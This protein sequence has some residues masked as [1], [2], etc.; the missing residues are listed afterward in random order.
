MHV[1][2]ALGCFVCCKEVAMQLRKF[3]SAGVF[4]CVFLQIIESRVRSLTPWNLAREAL[5]CCWCLM[6]FDVA[7]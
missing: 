2:G 6:C 1:F 7:G 4:F 3:R 5:L